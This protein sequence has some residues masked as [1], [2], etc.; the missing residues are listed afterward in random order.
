LLVLFGSSY[1]LNINQ[2]GLYSKLNEGRVRLIRFAQ[3][4]DT[5]KLMVVGFILLNCP[6]GFAGSVRC[7][8]EDDLH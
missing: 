8:H 6:Y 1:E 7:A 5:D 2:F 3:L 4:T